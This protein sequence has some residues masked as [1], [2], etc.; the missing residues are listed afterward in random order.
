MKKKKRD[1]QI[2]Y[3]N[4]KQNINNNTELKVTLK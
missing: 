1:L 2:I 3:D 4:Y